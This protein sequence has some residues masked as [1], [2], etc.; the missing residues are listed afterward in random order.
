MLTDQDCHDEGCWEP[1]G[2]WGPMN[3]AGCGQP[4]FALRLLQQYSSLS[5]IVNDTVFMFYAP[6]ETFTS[7]KLEE[8]YRRYKRWFERLPDEFRFRDVNLPHVLTLQ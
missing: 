1:L 2:D 4:T 8:F 5:E 3:I 6:R 7:A